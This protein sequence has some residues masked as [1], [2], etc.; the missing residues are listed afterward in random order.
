M[1]SLTCQHCG[2]PV[3][4][5]RTGPPRRYCNDRCKN[6]AETQRA[7]ARRN[8]YQDPETQHTARGLARFMAARQQR[9]AR[10]ERQNA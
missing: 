4:R 7:Q 10:A 2:A 6:R 9:L 3:T 5:A 1:P 8:G